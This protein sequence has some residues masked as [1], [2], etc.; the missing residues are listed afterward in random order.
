MKRL[1][2]KD[3]LL[4]EAGSGYAKQTFHGP[5]LDRWGI[6]WNGRRLFLRKFA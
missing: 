5:D 2:E 3:V 6:L 1:H 4:S